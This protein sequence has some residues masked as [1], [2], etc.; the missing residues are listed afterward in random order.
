[1]PPHFGFGFGFGYVASSVVADRQTDT[2]T[3]IVTLVH[4]PR[5]NEDKML[6]VVVGQCAIH[7]VLCVGCDLCAV[8]AC[9][10]KFVLMHVI[11]LLCYHLW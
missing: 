1:M 4:A 3:T 9:V 10:A 2:H 7:K 11:M 6:T 8:C 5:L